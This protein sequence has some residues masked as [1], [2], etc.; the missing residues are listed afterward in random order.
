MQA[1]INDIFNNIKAYIDLALGHEAEI[2]EYV[3]NSHI[4]MTFKHVL[5]ACEVES[6]HYQVYKDAGITFIDKIG[7]YFDENR[8]ANDGVSEIHRT[9]Q[10]LRHKD[11][12]IR[13]A[14][15]LIDTRISHECNMYYKC[16]KYTEFRHYMLPL[17]DSIKI[18]I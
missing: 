2:N 17:T 9:Y 16:R 1:Q 18:E 12:Y 11:D 15:K 5:E 13:Q 3:P 8:L 7:L 6:L 4:A 10:M 14:L